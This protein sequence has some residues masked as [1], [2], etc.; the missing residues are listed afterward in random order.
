MNVIVVPGFFKNKYFNAVEC[1]I[2]KKHDML[3]SSVSA[4]SVQAQY[5]QQVTFSGPD[6]QIRTGYTEGHY[7]AVTFE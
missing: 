5:P 4:N 1:K 2:I 3:Y 6:G 7:G